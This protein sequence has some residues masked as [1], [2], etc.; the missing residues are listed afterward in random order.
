[1]FCFLSHKIQGLHA[2]SS[3]APGTEV[4]VTTPCFHPPTLTPY[5]VLVLWLSVVEF[6][7][8]DS[9]ILMLAN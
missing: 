6:H 3:P 4:L 7:L 9:Y 2:R 5:F 8:V 1:M